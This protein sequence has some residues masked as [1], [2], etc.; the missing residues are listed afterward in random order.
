MRAPPSALGH[1]DG[2]VWTRRQS[3]GI[4]HGGWGDEQMW[5]GRKIGVF[6]FMGYERESKII[7]EKLVCSLRLSFQ[8]RVGL[9]SKVCLLRPVEYPFRNSGVKRWHFKK[10]RESPWFVG[11]N[12]WPSI[13]SPKNKPAEG[14]KSCFRLIS[15]LISRVLVILEVFVGK[16]CLI[17]LFQEFLETLSCLIS[18]H[19]WLVEILIN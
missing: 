6:R 12:P 16:G 11:H 5:R 18:L 13:E 19:S 3:E 4:V 17:I 15:S 2:S 10:C 9:L 1:G 8:K 7:L 14:L